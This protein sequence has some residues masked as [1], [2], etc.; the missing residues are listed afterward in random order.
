[1]T[2]VEEKKKIRV[3]AGT[4][5][6]ACENIAKETVKKMQEAGI[7]EAKT[8]QENNMIRVTCGEFETEDQA[9]K[10]IEEIK[11]AGFAA[12]ILA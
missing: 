3:A 11:K 5:M 6:E 2:K 4:Y 8:E 12:F 9:N 7:K 10:A 1:M